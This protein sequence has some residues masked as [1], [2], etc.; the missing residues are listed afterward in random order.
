MSADWSPVQR[1]LTLV[2]PLR[3]GVSDVVAERIR[4]MPASAANPIFAALESTRLVHFAR[5]VMLPGN[6]LGV[7]TTYDGDFEDYILAFVE[8]VGDIF[9]FLLSYV[10][11]ADG[12]CPVRDNPDAFVRYVYHHDVETLGA[13]YSAYPDMG[14]MD[15]RRATP[16]AR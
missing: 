12:V 1:A 8:R 7:I 4:S 9:D 16:A 2:M 5:F 10:A 6:N 15:I 11:D 14:V 13:F 3:C